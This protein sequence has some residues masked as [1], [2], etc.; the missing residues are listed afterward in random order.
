MECVRGIGQ[1]HLEVYVRMDLVHYPPQGW[2]QR[3]LLGGGGVAPIG[4]G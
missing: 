4:G 1:L 2:I 3:L